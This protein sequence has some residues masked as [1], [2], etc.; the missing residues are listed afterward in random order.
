MSF[1]P[2]ETKIMR[3]GHNATRFLEW[4]V[5]NTLFLK[6]LRWD[7]GDGNDDP[8][9]HVDFGSYFDFA[10]E[11]PDDYPNYPEDM[12]EVLGPEDGVPGL[13]NRRNF[14]YRIFKTKEVHFLYNMVICQRDELL[15]D[16]NFLLDEWT[17]LDRN[18]FVFWASHTKKAERCYLDPIRRIMLRKSMADGEEL[19]ARLHLDAAKKLKEAPSCAEYIAWL[20]QPILKSMHTQRES[21]TSRVQ[22]GFNTDA[23]RQVETLGADGNRDINKRNSWKQE[24]LAAQAASVQAAAVEAAEVQAEAVQVAAI[25]LKKALIDRTEAS[26]WAFHN[27]FKPEW[28]AHVKRL[29]DPLVIPDGYESDDDEDD[30]ESRYFPSPSKESYHWSNI[31]SGGKIKAFK[32]KM[33]FMRLLLNENDTSL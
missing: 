27:V 20:H 25:A 11:S 1:R 16:L 28:K 19:P 23:L 4:N 32:E 22:R 26:L 2:P 3:P 33:T 31:R 24:I 6:V 30:E 7:P 9:M 29:R 17:R 12:D 8:T 21:I 15:G 18:Q 14:R 10:L 5:N 13:W